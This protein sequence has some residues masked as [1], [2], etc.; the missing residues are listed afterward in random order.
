MLVHI[1]VNAC[2]QV[3]THVVMRDQLYALFVQSHPPSLPWDK[4]LSLAWSPQDEQLDWLISKAPGSACFCPPELR[5]KAHCTMPV[6]F[7]FF[8]LIEGWTD[9]PA[10]IASTLLTGPCLESFHGCDIVSS[11]CVNRHCR[12]FPQK[13]N[14]TAYFLHLCKVSLII[15]H[16]P[17]EQYTCHDCWASPYT[18]LPTVHL[19]WSL[20]R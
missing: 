7:F 3:C 17:P 9:F 16:T 20:P 12:P 13:G 5:L 8:F 14:I 6:F 10:C 18:S 4:G 11:S 2:V 15:T 1:H 19:H